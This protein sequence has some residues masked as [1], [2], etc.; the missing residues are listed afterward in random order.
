MNNERDSKSK[1]NI[2]LKVK[3]LYHLQCFFH[4][5]SAIASNG[6]F[7]E[8]ENTVDK[9]KY[10]NGDLPRLSELQSEMIHV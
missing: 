1:V 10:R 2:I 9:M 5:F 8:M 6:K 4:K 7:G 3:T